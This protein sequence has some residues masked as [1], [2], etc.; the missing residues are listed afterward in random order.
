MVQP[1]RYTVFYGQRVGQRLG[2]GIV[3]RGKNPLAEQHIL[4]LRIGLLH[5]G[6]RP[7]N[8]A[9]GAGNAFLLEL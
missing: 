4:C 6:G 7:G 3:Q 5:R 1:L 9:D 8:R 2:L